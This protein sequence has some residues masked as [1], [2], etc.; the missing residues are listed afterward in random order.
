LKQRLMLMINPVSGKQAG[1]KNEEEL[2][3]VLSQK[4]LVEVF[5]TTARGDATLFVKEQ[6]E[7]YDFIACCGGDGTLNEVITG[8]FSL[9][10]KPALICLPAGTT[11]LLADTLHIPIKQILLAAEGALAAPAQPFDIGKMNE[12]Y[13]S[14]VVSFGAFADSSYRTPQKLKN[15]L[16]YGAYVIGGARSLFAIRSYSLQ[17][18]ANGKQYDGDYIFGSVSNCVAV[19]GIIKFAENVVQVADG[20]YEVVLIKKPRSPLALW[21]TL[22]CIR[23]KEYDDRYVISFQT[24]ALSLSSAKEI[25]WTIDGEY[26]GTFGDVCI[27]VYPGAVSILY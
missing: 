11:N 19:G 27:Q 14:S 2:V 9:E 5:R 3:E 15:K 20:L 4:Y 25:P 21:R 26:R 17:V 18:T 6:G 10:K 8:L 16:G 22:S 23:K 7:A 13:F 12:H 24:D 1:L